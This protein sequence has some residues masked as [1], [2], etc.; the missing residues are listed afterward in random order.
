MIFVAGSSNT[1]GLWLCHSLVLHEHFATK[2]YSSL[3]NWG[4]LQNHTGQ[5]QNGDKCLKTAFKESQ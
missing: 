2:K 5:L 1:M 4:Y 3:H